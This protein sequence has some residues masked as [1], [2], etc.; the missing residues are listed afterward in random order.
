M[1]ILEYGLDSKRL[2]LLEYTKPSQ[3][4]AVFIFI[5]HIN[6]YANE[7]E[8]PCFFNANLSA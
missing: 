5:P 7:F 6:W 2:I 1:G 3:Y 4:V 8:A